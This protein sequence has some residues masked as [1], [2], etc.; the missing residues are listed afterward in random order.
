MSYFLTYIF[1]NNNNLI[2]SCAKLF[3]LFLIKRSYLQMISTLSSTSR[4]IITLITKSNTWS[5]V[6]SCLLKT[7]SFSFE[8]KD[9][10]N[11][12]KSLP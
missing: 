3:C 7:T 1:T 5:R 6:S 8:Q 4:E 11:N 9:I 10:F 12:R 2:K